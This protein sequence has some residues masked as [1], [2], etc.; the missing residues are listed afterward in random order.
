MA[1]YRDDLTKAIIN[2]CE[3]VKRQVLLE[4]IQIAAG[5]DTFDDFKKVLYSRALGFMKEFEDQG[6]LK[7]G[8]V[9]RVAKGGTLEDEDINNSDSE[10]I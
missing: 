5:C 1:D 7:P 6:V 9:E 2:Q 8:T 10:I 3:I 4:I